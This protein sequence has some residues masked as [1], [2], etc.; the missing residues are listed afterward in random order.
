MNNILED[1]K[2]IDNDMDKILDDDIAIQSFEIENSYKSMC[3]CQR[4]EFDKFKSGHIQLSGKRNDNILCFSFTL[5][6]ENFRYFMN[7]LKGFE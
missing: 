3:V 1:D 6:P 7:K 5:D 2:E 4:I